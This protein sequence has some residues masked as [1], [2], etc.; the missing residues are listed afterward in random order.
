MCIVVTISKPNIRCDNQSNYMI[1]DK[2]DNLF[3]WNVFGFKKIMYIYLDLVSRYTLG[4]R[5]K[6]LFLLKSMP[7]RVFLG[8]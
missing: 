7:N 4:Y 8:L 2:I 3:G 5:F 1:H 6:V